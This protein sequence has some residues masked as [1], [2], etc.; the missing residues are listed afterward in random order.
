MTKSSI[1]S[2]VADDQFA[3]SAGGCHVW[4]ARPSLATGNH[5]RFLSSVEQDRRAG[6]R[7]KVDRD[8]F[9]TA[10]A[11]LR[12]VVSQTVGCRPDAVRI[13]RVC[14]DC[15]RSHGKPRV[16]GHDLAVS[17]SHSGDRVA[18]ACG[19]LDEVGVDVEEIGANFDPLLLA[20]EVLAPAEEI[21]F[22]SLPD[23]QRTWGL[24]NYWTRKESVL[25]ATGVGMRVPFSTVHVSAPFHPPKLLAH[26]HDPDTVPT[27]SLAA[28]SPGAGYV[29]CLAGLGACAGVW[30]TEWDGDALLKLG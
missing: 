25:K 4:W 22:N 18:V 7:R 20:K 12:L 24:L 2:S 10:A 28:L 16:I 19:R 6:F 23:V 1:R 30:V 8:R 3:L 9:S 13:S 14:P 26:D 15:G 5:E 21:A 27:M 11:L 29:A 17:V